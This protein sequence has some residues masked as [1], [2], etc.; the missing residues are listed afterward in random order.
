MAAFDL[1]LSVLNPSLERTGIKNKISLKTDLKED[2][3]IRGLPLGTFM[4]DLMTPNKKAAVAYIKDFSKVCE[5]EIRREA[6]SEEDWTV[7]KNS[8]STLDTPNR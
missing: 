2:F 3:E 1:S 8:C 6:S 4:A 7:L 5:W